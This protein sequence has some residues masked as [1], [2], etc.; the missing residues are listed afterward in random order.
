MTRV[1][2]LERE[3]E[4]MKMKHEVL[5]EKYAETHNDL[6]KSQMAKQME[7]LREKR[8][9]ERSLKNLSY[10]DMLLPISEA[11]ETR[12]NSVTQE[13]SQMIRALESM[14]IDT[15]YGFGWAIRT[16]YLSLH[17]IN[18]SSMRGGLEMT[19]QI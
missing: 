7:A 9:S 15:K 14:N 6:L 16:D 17:I 2:S 11:K 3:L 12:S 8:Q 18:Q 1:K 4:E 13:S 19:I 10:N 5:Q